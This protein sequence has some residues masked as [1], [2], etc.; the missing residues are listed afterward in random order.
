[1]RST[2]VPPWG[3]CFTSRAEVVAL[4]AVR[5][6]N[7]PK[8]ATV[9]NHP[10]ISRDGTIHHTWVRALSTAGLIWNAPTAMNP[11]A[12]AS[13]SVRII[14]PSAGPGQHGSSGS[15]VGLRSDDEFRWSWPRKSPGG[16]RRPATPARPL[17][18]RCEC[19]VRHRVRELMVR[20]RITFN[21]FT[22]H[23]GAPRRLLEGP[24][25]RCREPRRR[26]EH[27]ALLEDQRGTQTHKATR[28]I[29]YVQERH[30]SSCRV[31]LVVR[32]HSCYR[33]QG[34]SAGA[35]RTQ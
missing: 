12:D 23:H 21:L 29:R 28:C 7:Q 4:R 33:G 31:V 34:G 11:S 10:T 27:H 18:L 30:S 1:M 20:L 6:W 22:P 5:L 17:L 2:R 19:W 15:M 8:R 26:L 35:A 9:S 3:F 24:G 25:G 14:A 13:T 32:I 16:G